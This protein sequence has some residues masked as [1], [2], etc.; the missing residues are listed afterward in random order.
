MI[1]FLLLIGVL[2]VAA[3]AIAIHGVR[4]I[5]LLVVLV[6]LT[7]LPRTRVW[8]IGENALVRLTGSR[9]R[10]YVL[11]TFVLIAVLIGVN[12]YQYVH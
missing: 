4:A 11:A 5:A 1:R 3:I 6:L 2:V 12:V 8:R 9:R 10:A 7:T